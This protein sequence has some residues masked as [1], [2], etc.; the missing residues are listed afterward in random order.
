[1]VTF[2]YI[3]P[4]FQDGNRHRSFSMTTAFLFLLKQTTEP[5]A[6]AH[7]SIISRSQTAKKT[8]FWNCS[9]QFLF[10]LHS[11]PFISLLKPSKTSYVITS[12]LFPYLV[13]N[14]PSTFLDDAI[15][16][17]ILLSIDPSLISNNL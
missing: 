4:S 1:M 17:T 8:N 15:T 13:S 12:P 16:L 11:R 2:F 10:W 6:T 9:F 7:H 14:K 5:L 3:E